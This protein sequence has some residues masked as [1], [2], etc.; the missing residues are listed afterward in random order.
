MSQYSIKDW[1]SVIMTSKTIQKK[2]TNGN[3]S[4]EDIE[5]IK[6]YN[7]QELKQ[8]KESVL[9]TYHHGTP[10]TENINKQLEK[11]NIEM[12]IEKDR[13]LLK[14]HIHYSNRI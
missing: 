12:T 10:D 3:L 8:L 2:S 11:N 4:D 1:N 7:M 14:Y 6:K 5:D 9:F 13:Y